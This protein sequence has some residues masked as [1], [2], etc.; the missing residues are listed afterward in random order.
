MELIHN[1]TFRILDG[2]EAGMYRVILDEIQIGKTAVVRLDPDESATQSKG[3]R[4]RLEVTRRPRKKARPPMLGEI[5]WMDRCELHRLKEGEDIVVIEVE[6]ENYRL[7]PADEALYAERRAAMAPFLDFDHFREMLLAHQGISGL[8]AEVVS[9]GWSESFVRTNFSHLCRYGFMESSLRP[10][11]SARCG[12]PGIPRPCDP[13]GRKKAGAKTT[14]ERVTRAFGHAAQPEQPGMSTLWTAA[15]LAADKRIPSPKPKM[16]ERCKQIVESAF[17]R[18]YKQVDGKLLSVELKLGEYPNTRQIRRVLEREIPRLQR[19]LESTTKAHF[20]RNLRGMVGRSWMGV[21]GPGHTWAIDSTIGDIYLRS[22]INRA[23]IIGRPIVY[24]IVDVWSTAIVGFYV[25]LDGPSWA[26][27]KVALFC[28]AMDPL[29]I[30]ELWGYEAMPC[31]NP[32]PT[33]CAVLLC[34]R[35]EYL[36]KAAKVTGARLIPC[37]SY[38]PPYRPD[39]KGLVEVLHRIKKDQQYFF[40]PGAIDQRRQEYELRRFDYNESALTIPEYVAFLYQM[41]TSYNLTAPREK[42][43]DAHMR[44]EGVFPSPAGLWGYGHRVGIG[45]RRNLLSSALIT[46]LLPSEPAHV[47]RNGVMFLGM[48]Y[49]SPMLKEQ[50]WT[51]LAR[52]FGSWNVDA[53]HFPGSVSRIWTR[54]A[55][56]PGLL[57]L[58]ISDHSTASSE[59]T[60]YEVID[61]FTYGKIGNAQTEHVRVAMALEARRKA[62]E[63]I[64]RAKVLTADAEQRHR[65]AKPSVTEARAFEA[66]T[67][68]PTATTDSGPGQTDD[69][70]RAA[71]QQMISALFAAANSAGQG[72]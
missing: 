50:Q 23:W 10:T 1:A 62:M 21:S 57:D 35:G 68:L 41:F 46:E 2:P 32:A 71:H 51:A 43:L 64:G 5:L 9:T 45:V 12:A 69:P 55:V 67:I 3:G 53:H 34:D 29:L 22:N 52:N 30:G 26:A 37:M 58:Q 17:V 14:K 42:R 36:S 63:I 38:T 72:S 27:A 13:G 18:R 54:N 24:V 39:L 56:G 66:A 7:S 47:T 59:L 11:R 40:V 15:I 16:P 6:T 61:A 4:K 25:C 48:E 44:A 28:A 8:V 70:A 60:F 65:G 33:M 49:Q 19:L 20:T 31:L